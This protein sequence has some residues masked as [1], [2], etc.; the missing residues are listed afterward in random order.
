MTVY[1][2]SG[3]DYDLA[4]RAIKE[5]GELTTPRLPGYYI[6]ATGCPYGRCGHGPARFARPGSV[7]VHL[8]QNHE[9]RIPV[10]WIEPATVP[11][12]NSKRASRRYPLG[13][14]GQSM[15]W[16]NRVVHDHPRTAMRLTAHRIAMC[17]YTAHIPGGP[18]PLPGMPQALLSATDPAAEH[19]EALRLADNQRRRVNQAAKRLAMRAGAA[20]DL[21]LAKRLE[22][23][24][25]AG[26]QA[27]NAKRSSKRLL[28]QTQPLVSDPA[29]PS[30]QE[31]ACSNMNLITFFP[32]VQAPPQ[33]EAAQPPLSHPDADHEARPFFHFLM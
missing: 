8:I 1:V 20:T 27:R 5:N 25:L 31:A 28:A 16:R 13:E 10:R 19:M 30:T 29:G 14:D 18:F 11:A 15:A 32:L 9:G 22:A 17:L 7:D 26:N 21:G 24:R 23:E 2:K 12:P 3:N 6:K 4:R 33:L